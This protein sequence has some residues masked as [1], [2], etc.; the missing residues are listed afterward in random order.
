ME[1]PDRLIFDLDPDPALPWKKVVEAAKLTRTLL[2]ELGLVSFLKTSG[3]NGLHVVVPLVRRHTWAASKAFA[4]AVSDHLAK[5]IPALFSAKMGAQNRVGKVFV[6]YLRNGRGST[7]VCAFSVRARP[8]LGVSLPISWQQLE[9]IRASDEFN[10]MTVQ[11][12]LR[13]QKKDPWAD[14][15]KSRQSLGEAIRAL[16]AS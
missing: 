8:G 9:E 11:S 5:I 7:T 13:K 6:D 3:G 12:V 4:K 2:Q 1:H 15:E 14:Y 10:I 16:G